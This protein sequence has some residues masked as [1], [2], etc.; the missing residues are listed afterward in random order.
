MTLGQEITVGPFHFPVL[1]LLIAVGLIRI[2]VRGEG[3]PA[4][5]RGLDRWMFAWATWAIVSSLFRED[6]P[7]SLVNRLGLVFNG[8]GTYVLFRVFCRSTADLINVGRIIAWLLV[9]LMLEMMSERQTGRNLF[10][11]FGSVGELPEVRGGVL[12]AQGP[13]AH[14][15]LAGSVG[16]ACLPLMAGIWRTHR[17]SAI[18]GASACLLIVYASASSGPILSAVCACVALA[19]WPLRKHMR[20]VRWSVVGVYALLE[21]VMNAPAYYL[22]ARIDMTGSSTSWHRAE[23]I[24]TAITHLSEWWLIGTDVTRHWMSYGVGWSSNHIDITNY[25]INMGVYGG[26]LLMLLFIAV[27]AKG[28]SLVGDETS[29]SV[30]SPDQPGSRFTMWALGAALFT[31]AATFVSISYFDQSV[32]FLYLTLAAIGGARG[33]AK[34]DRTRSTLPTA[35]GYR[36]RSEQQRLAKP[37]TGRGFNEETGRLF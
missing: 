9:P 14:P 11:A 31:H 17:L 26:L 33:V 35:L 24:N 6:V 27:M 18:V 36:A 28:F 21:L 13:F 7:A 4:S 3:L 10:A 29:Q 2:A 34:A 15:I 19:A 22:L 1:R 12:R 16:A 37:G 5:S 32:V 30:D 8:L 25:Y 23:L 20:V